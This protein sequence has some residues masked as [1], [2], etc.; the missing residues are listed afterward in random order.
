[1][2]AQQ[3]HC[4]CHLEGAGGPCEVRI[5]DRACPRHG[6]DRPVHPGAPTRPA[7]VATPP[8]GTRGDERRKATVR[9]LYARYAVPG[10]PVAWALLDGLTADATDAEAGA[11][12]RAVR[13][14]LAE[15]QAADEAHRRD[16]VA[17]AR[18]AEA[19]P[20]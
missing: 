4:T 7:R 10:L 11:W 3:R 17:A 1:M 6:D 20:S 9:E 16:L 19:V 14:V 2:S 13:D 18:T 12:L 8:T 5:L 15:L